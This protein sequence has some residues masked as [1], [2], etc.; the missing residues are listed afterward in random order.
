LAEQAQAR[1]PLPE[2]F[3]PITAK[4]LRFGRAG[5]RG[6][7]RMPQLTRTTKR[8]GYAVASVASVVGVLEYKFQECIT[9]VGNPAQVTSPH[10]L[11]WLRTLFG[12]ARSRWLGS[13]SEAYVPVAMRAPLY[14][15]FASRYGV[16]LEEIRY[17]L[18]AYR[19]F[20]DFFGRALRDGVRPIAKLPNGLVSPVDGCVMTHGVVEGWDA[21]VDQVKGASYHVPALLGV[22]PMELAAEDREV[23]F[24]VLYLGPGDYHRIHSP[25][26][27]SITSGRHFSGELLPVRERL[28][29]R[30][31]DIFTVNERVVLS[32][33][34]RFGNMNMVLVAAANVGNIWLDFDEKLKTN[35]LRDIPVYCGGDISAK[36]YHDSHELNAGSTVGGF[37]LGSTVVLVFD[38]PKGFEFK[39]APGDKVQVGVPLGGVA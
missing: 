5:R 24:I 33:K 18:D 7:L 21:R 34:W 10:S 14:N 6:R 20:Q 1:G 11:F 35:R 25:A 4:M 8:W 9:V 27:C 37:K 19:T 2:P 23:H 3:A 38:A 31:S 17:P 28:L 39:V 32:G 26:K 36:K 12:R 15:M 22:D 16:N 29:S 13:M 30:L